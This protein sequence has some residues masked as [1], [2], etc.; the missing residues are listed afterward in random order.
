MSS[1]QAIDTTTRLITTLLPETNPEPP[2]IIPPA[3]LNL[4]TAIKKIKKER[5]PT[6][7]KD[8]NLYLDIYKECK[9]SDLTKH[10]KH[11]K[12]IDLAKEKTEE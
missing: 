2:V 5:T 9:S 6:N 3:E 8:Q 4:I 7:T 10:Y 12:M 11:A 1:P